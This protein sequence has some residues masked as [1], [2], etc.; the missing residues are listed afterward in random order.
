MGNHALI[1]ALCRYLVKFTADAEIASPML[2]S[3]PEGVRAKRL[4]HVSPLGNDHKVLGAADFLPP[5][6]MEDR[7]GLDYK[8]TLLPLPASSLGEG[9]VGGCGFLPAFCPTYTSLT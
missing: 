8:E 2:S 3:A 1:L 6:K 7:N 9:R 5:F 4:T